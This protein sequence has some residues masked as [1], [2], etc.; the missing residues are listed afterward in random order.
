MCTRLALVDADLEELAAAL[1]VDLQRLDESYVNQLMI[2]PPVH[3]IDLR[4]VALA[5]RHAPIHLRFVGL[6]ALSLASLTWAGSEVRVRFLRNETRG[7]AARNDQQFKSL[8]PDQP[9]IAELAVQLNAL[10][11]QRT[12]PQN[13][14]IVRPVSLMDKLCNRIE[15]HLEGIQTNPP[16]MAN[17]ASSPCPRMP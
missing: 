4:C 10:Q 16:R 7:L 5:P 11:R 6:S 1:L 14:R 13:N 8:Y 15:A 2:A 3:A 12:E 17:K 9:R